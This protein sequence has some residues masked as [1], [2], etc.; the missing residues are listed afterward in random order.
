MGNDGGS[1]PTRRELVKEAARSLTTTQVKESQQEQQ[2][3]NWTTCP[4]SHRPLSPPIVS[5][6]VGKLYNKDAVLQFLLP[7][8]DDNNDDSGANKVDQEEFL[9]GR[10]RSLK[11]VIEVKFEIDADH[12]RDA[13]AHRKERWVCPITRKELGPNVKSV[14]LVPCGHAFSESA[15]KEVSE[16]ICLQCNEPFSADNIIPILPVAAADID[17]LTARAKSLKEQGL[18]HSL[19]KA[20]GSSKKRKKNNHTDNGEMAALETEPINAADVVRSNKPSKSSTPQPQ[21]NGGNANAAGTKGGIKNAAT[22]SLTA[23]VLGDELEK[24]K[25]RKLVSKYYK[26]TS[27]FTCISHPSVTIPINKLNDDYCDCPDGSD[28]PGTSACSYLSP[29]SP[30]FPAKISIPGSHHVPKNTTPILPGYYCKNKGH[31]PSYIPFSAVNDGTCD[32]TKCCDGSDEYANVGGIVCPDLCK[33]IGKEWR[34]LDELRKKSLGAGSKRR[35]ELEM[36]SVT[37]KKILEE[38][39]V[40]NEGRVKAAEGQVEMLK[41]ELAEVEKRERGKVV[42]GGVAGGGG[43]M[44]VLVNLA[45]ERIEELKKSLVMIRGQRDDARTKVKELEIILETFKGEFNPNFNDEGVKR[46]VRSWE[47]YA[48]KKESSTKEEVEESDLE[49]ILN[50]DEEGGGINWDEFLISSTP[51]SDVEHLYDLKRYLPPT[52]LTWIDTQL[53]SLKQYLIENGLLADNPSDSSTTSSDSPALSSARNTLN[54]AEEELTSQKAHL[55]PLQADLR[56]RYFGPD[57]IFRPLKDKCFSMDQ[58]EYE[59]EVCL[60]G[61][62]TQKPKKG[63]GNVHLGKFEK[64]DSV[65]V[66]EDEEDEGEGDDGSGDKEGKKKRLTMKYENG[67]Q[68][69]NG[70]IRQTTVVLY[71]HEKDGVVKKVVEEE[72]C[73]YRIDMGSAAACSSPSLSSSSSSSTGGGGGG[74]DKKGVK[75]EL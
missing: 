39:V 71:C 69:W 72:K 41:K 16:E 66:D 50:E 28:E 21:P 56:E 57:E 2:A 9:A 23:R 26:S 54:K 48:A 24:N 35:K 19:K 25:R 53:K 15:I 46:A 29:L 1:I 65:Y 33:E 10:I 68:C 44:N 59:Y 36:E 47:E 30:P 40:V 14:Y 62:V 74:G 63:G 55:Q 42:K 8:E 43:G 4:L 3:Y 5:D 27:T 11:D 6:C 73:V 64:F 60:M 61:S 67:Q 51:E 70:P 37:M 22:A 38:E 7:S 52:L 34:R 49:A 31:R 75:D 32:S 45:K 18:T 20:S 58:G 13:A 12:P 17:R